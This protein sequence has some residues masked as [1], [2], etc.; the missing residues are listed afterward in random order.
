MRRDDFIKMWKVSLSFME[1]NWWFLRG[2]EVKYTEG[3]GKQK[4]CEM[5]GFTLFPNATGFA[6]RFP[7]EKGRHART[8]PRDFWFGF[9][10]DLPTNCEHLAL[11]PAC[12]AIPPERI[13]YSL[14]P[15]RNSR[16]PHSFTGRKIKYWWGQIFMKHCQLLCE[17]WQGWSGSGRLGNQIGYGME[18]NSNDFNSTKFHHFIMI[19]TGWTSDPTHSSQ[20]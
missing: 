20:L 10:Y 3:S 11:L 14:F 12:D 5:K 13:I 2:D 17:K 19:M 1:F 9:W 15:F 4:S 6:G 8:R 16:F 18:W 7:P